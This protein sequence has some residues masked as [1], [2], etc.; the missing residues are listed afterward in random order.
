[1][2]KEAESSSEDTHKDSESMSGVLDWVL[3]EA[4][5]LVFPLMT[6]SRVLV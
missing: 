4:K 3:K 1:V 6:S 5:L 2:L